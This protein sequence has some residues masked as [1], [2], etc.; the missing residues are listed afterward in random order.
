MSVM[1]VRGGVPRIQRVTVNSTGRRFT[2]NGGHTDPSV[3]RYN[4]TTEYI[5]I[6]NVGANPVNV[7]F[8]EEDFSNDV[9]YIAIAASGSWEGP[10]E[11]NAYWMKSA[12]GTTVEVVAFQRRG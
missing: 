7:F 4:F 8:L 1:T 3:G 9:N 6:R 5:Q 12:S 2:P 10:A 11:L